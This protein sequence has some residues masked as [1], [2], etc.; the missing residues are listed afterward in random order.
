MKPCLLLLAA[1]AVFAGC[2]STEVPPEHEP[3]VRPGLIMLTADQAAQR[4]IELT[5]P[6]HPVPV[7]LPST[8]S[9][10]DTNAVIVPPGIKVYALNRAADPA[11]P[12]VMHEQHLVYRRE[13]T[14]Q[15][16]LDTPPT[17]QLLIGPSVVD[18]RQDIQPVLTKELTSFLLEQ[19]R[20]TE[21]NQRAIETLLHAVDAL[22]RQNQILAQRLPAPANAEPAADRGGMSSSEANPAGDV[23]NYRQK[24][25]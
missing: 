19:R 6:P 5:P 7:P 4:G 25:K 18:G 23:A 10:V 14:P 1:S 2:A 22:D 9:P 13:S 12:E 24:A 8:L 11:D 3:Y 16:R 15:W 17:Q 21:T 20:A